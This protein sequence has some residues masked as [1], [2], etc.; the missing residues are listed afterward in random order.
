MSIPDRIPIERVPDYY[1]HYVGRSAD[2]RQFMAFIV[3]TLPKPSPPDWER[4]KRWYA[5]LHTFDREGHH[6]NTEAR[7]VGLT[8]DGEADVCERARG[9][10]KELLASLGKRRYCDVS[11]RLFSVRVDGHLFGLEETTDEER[12]E[13]VTLWPNDFFFTPPWNGNYST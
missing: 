6:L 10:R 13:S 11:I 2:G 4:H 12:G 5:V 7:F 8:S 3:A 9:L 1:T